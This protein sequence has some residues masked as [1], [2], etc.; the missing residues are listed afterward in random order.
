MH[1]YEII[2][3]ESIHHL[4]DINYKEKKEEKKKK[5]FFRKKI[6]KKYQKIDVSVLIPITT[7]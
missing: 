7:T 3:D 4:V 5:I 1:Q 2:L 6:Q